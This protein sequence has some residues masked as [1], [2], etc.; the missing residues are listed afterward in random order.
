MIVRAVVSKGGR[1][2]DLV[3]GRGACRRGGQ[4]GCSIS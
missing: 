3:G 2:V 1:M 4:I